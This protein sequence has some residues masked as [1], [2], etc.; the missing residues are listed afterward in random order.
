MPFLEDSEEVRLAFAVLAGECPIPPNTDSTAVL[1]H[2]R[3]VLRA[4]MDRA[5]QNASSQSHFHLGPKQQT[6]APVVIMP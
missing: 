2:H 4:A 5:W 6:A 1:K 3:A